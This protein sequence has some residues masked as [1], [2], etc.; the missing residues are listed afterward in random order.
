[1]EI[2]INL[3]QM[4]ERYVKSKEFQAEWWRARALS[5]L[6]FGLGVGFMAGMFIAVWFLQ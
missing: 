6:V 5:L 2:E 3:D 1:M 4:T